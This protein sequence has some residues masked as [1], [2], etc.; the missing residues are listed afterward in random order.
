[1]IELLTRARVW[2]ETRADQL[3]GSVPVMLLPER[4]SVCSEV[5]AD[6]EEGREPDQVFPRRSRWDRVEADWEREEAEG[7]GP[8]RPRNEMSRVQKREDYWPKSYN[9]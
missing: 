1:M 9:Q 8:A 7:K 6:H 5:R 3:S 2:R 4:S